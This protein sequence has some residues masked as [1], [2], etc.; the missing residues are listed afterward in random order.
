MASKTEVKQFIETLS[1]LAIAERRK[2]A[3][4]VLPSVCIAQAA[5]E[6]GWG[7]SKLMTKANAYFGIKAGKTWK[8]KVYDAKTSECYDGSTYVRITDTFR[9]YDSLAESVSDYYDLIT[10][11]SRYSKAVNNNNALSTITAIKDGG[12]ATS[13]TYITNVMSIINQYNLTQYDNIE[14]KE[15]QVDNMETRVCVYAYSK[16]KDGNT[17]LTANFK[18]KEF[19][20]KDNSDVIF[21]AP[22]LVEVL[23]KVRTH[24]GKP[25]NITSGYRTPTYNKKIGGATYSQHTY[26]IGADIKVTGVKPTEVAKYIETLLPNTGGIGIYSTFV[27]VDVRKDKSRWNG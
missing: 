2:R 21:I 5:L 12:Y 26:G 15:E 13:P 4:W 1:K 23:Q 11:L 16:A 6:T 7:T 19:A 22:Q 25:V 3:K 8:G 20:C 10:G 14:E 27:H 17:K 24:F 9:A 18:V